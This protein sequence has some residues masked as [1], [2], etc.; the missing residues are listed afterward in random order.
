MAVRKKSVYLETT[1]PSFATSR[2]SRD[3]I[4]ASRQLITKYFWE[5]ERQNYDLA[6][7]QVVIDECGRGD[8]DAAQRRLDF[9]K[10]IRLIPETKKIDEL[11]E[12]YYALL[13]IPERA[14]AD[15]SHL[16]VCVH[17]KM[18]YLLSWNCTHLGLTSYT[19]ILSYNDKCGLWTPVLVTPDTLMA[20]DE[21]DV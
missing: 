13:D 17:E 2:A 3:I 8:P 14:K 5:N 7:S 20:I 11:A 16:A 1:I 12:I 9:I 19:K 18:D 21:E 6:I 10:G 15:C 4:I